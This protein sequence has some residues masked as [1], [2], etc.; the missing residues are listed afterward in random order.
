MS[1]A[2]EAVATIP[3]EA[4]RLFILLDC[5][6]HSA[7]AADERVVLSEYLGCLALEVRACHRRGVDVQ[8]VVT[9]VSGGGIFAALAAAVGTVSML[10]SARLHI[11]PRA[12]MA[13]INRSEDESETTPTRALETG[14]ADRILSQ[15]M[16]DHAGVR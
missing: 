1:P 16:E 2:S 4:E 9:G 13:A 11:L 6:S 12:A 7:K 10:P 5:E 3:R 14:A 15:G 8:L